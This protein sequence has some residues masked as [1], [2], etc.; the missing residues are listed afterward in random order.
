MKAA[1]GQMRTAP[2]DRPTENM[3]EACRLAAE[4]GAAG[5]SL[6]LLPEGCLT[7]NALKDPARQAVLP[8]KAEAFS[9][10]SGI[11]RKAGLTICAGFTLAV[12]GGF[13]VAHAIVR[14]DGAVLFQY[15]AFR[16]STEP[17]YLKAWPDPARTPF[18]VDGLG[19]VITICSEF[20]QPAVMEAVARYKPDVILHPSAG[21]MKEEEVWRPGRELTPAVRDFS[22]NCRK[23]VDGAAK[24]NI[25][26]GIT[27]LAANPVGHDGETWWPGNGYA[28]SGKGDILAWVEGENHPDHM[29]SRLGYVTL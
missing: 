1:I 16:A 4:A 7:G 9:P 17:A 24:A 13:T 8:A 14:P 3:A 15:K 28:V 29:I 2:L 25:R 27:R 18:T 23:V 10:L 22:L 26:T 6:L 11:A 19:I 5:A 12:E 21:C 20:G